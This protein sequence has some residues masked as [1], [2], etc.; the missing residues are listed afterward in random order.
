MLTLVT[1]SDFLPVWR[2]GTR[3][4]ATDFNKEKLATS[5]ALD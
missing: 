5:L 1:F 4:S 3:R 2:V